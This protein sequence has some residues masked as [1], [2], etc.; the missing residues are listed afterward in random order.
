MKSPSLDFRTLRFWEQHASSG[1]INV[2]FNLITSVLFRKLQPH[3]GIEGI[4]LSET[5]GQDILEYGVNIF[6]TVITR[7]DLYVYHMP[8]LKIFSAF[9]TYIVLYV[10]HMI[11]E[12]GIMICFLKQ[13]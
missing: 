8:S 5:H 6:I 10:F 13:H 4:F 12:I 3:D 11:P 1:D 2:N 9:F 7:S